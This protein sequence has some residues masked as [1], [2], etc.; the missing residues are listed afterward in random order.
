[1]NS[2]FFLRFVGLGS[3]NAAVLRFQSIHCTL[4]LAQIKNGVNGD[5]GYSSA[6]LLI[7][8]N[9]SVEGAGHGA[10]GRRL[11]GETMFMFWCPRV[12]SVR[13]CVLLGR[14]AK[15]CFG[16]KGCDVFW[17]GREERVG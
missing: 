17:W 2:S 11:T 5:V 1:M 13:E 7:P 6:S 9:G 14:E 3:I 12:C 16:F 8:E 4:H 15:Q 10:D